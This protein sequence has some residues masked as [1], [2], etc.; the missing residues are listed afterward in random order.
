MAE[1][2]L[3]DAR[4]AGLAVWASDAK[5]TTHEVEA[6]AREVQE[7]RAE[8]ERLRA[9]VDD[10][11]NGINWHTTCTNC[12]KLMD[13]NYDQYC[14]IERLRAAG[15]QLADALRDEAVHLGWGGVADR[16]LAVWEEARHG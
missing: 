5:P 4:V 6:L 12:A 1:Y 16:A 13:I 3:S 10:Y 8:I 7:S 14:Q 9:L 15:D 11:E 2:R